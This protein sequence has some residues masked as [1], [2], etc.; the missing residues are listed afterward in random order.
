MLARLSRLLAEIARPYSCDAVIPVELQANL[1]QLGVP[2][3]PTTPRET[4]IAQLWARKRSLETTLIPLWG[5]PG[6]SPPSAA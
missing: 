3:E 1:W 4:V 2:C 5:G 6:N